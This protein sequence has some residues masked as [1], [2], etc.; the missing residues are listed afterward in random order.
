MT[1]EDKVLLLK[2]LYAAF[3]RRDIEQVLAALSSDVKWPNVIDKI[4]IQGHS[5]IRD[6]WQKQFQTIDSI[7]EPFGFEQRN[8]DVAVLVHQRVTLKETNQVMESDVT[9]TYTFDNGL[10]TAM[11]VS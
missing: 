7:V 11:V 6:Y 10:I 3:N 4:T 2:E 9:H 8:G 1:F 5:E